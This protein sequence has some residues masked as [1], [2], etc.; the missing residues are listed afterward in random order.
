MKRL[1][2][3]AALAAAPAFADNEMAYM[4][5]KAGGNIFFT[6][7]RCVYVSNNQPI[8][9]NFYMYSTDEY[10]NKLADGCYEYKPPFYLVKWNSGTRTSVPTSQVT[11]LK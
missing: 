8:P 1:L 7:S 3:I 5:N 2:L 9:K 4:P 10:G 11:L 6:F